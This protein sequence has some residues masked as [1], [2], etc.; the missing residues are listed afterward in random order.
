MRAVLILQLILAP[1]CLADS[2]RAVELPAPAT[3]S[4]T[5]YRCRIQV[6]E[7]LVVPEANNERDL[8]RSSTMLVFS[9]MPEGSEV[10]LNGVKIITT[11]PVPAGQTRRFKVPKGI[12]VARKFNTL[13]VRLDE[14]SLTVPP[15][16]IDYF[17]EL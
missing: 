2:W 1:L 12:L 5:W 10:W 11:G 3:G 15:L 14:G 17:H 8:W 6:P 4:P 9:G 7:R 16:L 13:A